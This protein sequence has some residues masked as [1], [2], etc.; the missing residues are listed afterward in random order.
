LSRASKAI[1]TVP[2]ERWDV[3]DWYIEGAVQ[4]GKTNTRH[5][6]FLAGVGQFDA[7]HFRIPPSEAICMSPSQCQLLQHT[8]Q[9]LSGAEVEGQQVAV[10]IG[11]CH[12]DFERLQR[13]AEVGTPYITT[14]TAT[15]VLA[16]YAPAMGF[17]L[18]C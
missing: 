2:H 7:L 10:C 8:E 9:A 11:S 16:G 4:P 18:M 1:C 12:H 5:G 3:D 15:S 13:S 17:V 6:G 14:G